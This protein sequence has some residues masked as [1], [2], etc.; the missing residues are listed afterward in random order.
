MK[1]KIS[2]PRVA[3]IG[4]LLKEIEEELENKDSFDMDDPYERGMHD[5][6]RWV[7]NKLRSLPEVETASAYDE[8][9]GRETRP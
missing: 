3:D 8:T 1:M 2:R 7:R 9:F 4:E 5:E 6:L